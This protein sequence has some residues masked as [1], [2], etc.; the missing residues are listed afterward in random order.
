M[1]EPVERRGPGAG[2]PRHAAPLFDGPDH[3]VFGGEQSDAR[4][5][6]GASEVAAELGHHRL[7]G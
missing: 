7:G 2:Q 1:A 3:E 4:P 6:R 5:L